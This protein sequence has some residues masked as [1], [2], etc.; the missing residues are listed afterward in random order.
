MN[1]TLV[2]LFLSLVGNSDTSVNMETL[3]VRTDSNTET[4]CYRND[5]GHAACVTT[6]MIPRV[7]HTVNH[8]SPRTLHVRTHAPRKPY[9]VLSKRDLALLNTEVSIASLNSIL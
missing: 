1:P 4:V 2:A 8:S 3:R 6:R 9:I 5:I 7:T